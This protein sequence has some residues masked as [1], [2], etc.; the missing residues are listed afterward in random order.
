MVTTPPL[1]PLSWTGWCHLSST[2]FNAQGSTGTNYVNSL[3]RILPSHLPGE[4][5]ALY[6]SRGPQPPAQLQA[7]CLLSPSSS[8]KPWPTALADLLSGTSLPFTEHGQVGSQKL[9]CFLPP[10][11]RPLHTHSRLRL[12][13][14][15]PL[16]TA[17]G[18]PPAINPFLHLQP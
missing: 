12:T 15:L 11:G 18:P 8:P 14:H 6:L 3:S 2:L 1:S 13:P 10:T 7:V 16:P 9:L 17:T 4:N 5:S